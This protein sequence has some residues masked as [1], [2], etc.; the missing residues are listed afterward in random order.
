MEAAFHFSVILGSAEKDFC[1]VF[2]GELKI[3]PD[4]Y[5][6]WYLLSTESSS[7]A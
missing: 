2:K 7:N 4:K 6:S 1:P 5:S 3:H